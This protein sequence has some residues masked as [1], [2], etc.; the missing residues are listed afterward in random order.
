MLKHR[1]SGTVRGQ[2]GGSELHAGCVGSTGE[3]PDSCHTPAT[4]VPPTNACVTGTLQGN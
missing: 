4:T 2:E 1:D 3:S